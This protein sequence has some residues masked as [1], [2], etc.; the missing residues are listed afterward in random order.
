MFILLVREKQNGFKL[1]FL[2][3]HFDLHILLLF[4]KMLV[5]WAAVGH[6]LVNEICVTN[7]ISNISI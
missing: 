1:F 3:H 4:E 7:V 2:N 6:R 5:Y